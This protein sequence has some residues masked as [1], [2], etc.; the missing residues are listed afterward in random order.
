M[1][2]LAPLMV[3]LSLGASVPTAWS[4]P[5]TV[6]D[7]TVEVQLIRNATVR[8]DFSGTTFLVDPMLSAKGEF[9][10]FPGTYRSELRNPLVDLPF[11]AKEVLDSVEAVVVTHTHTD[12]WDE[13]AQKAIPKDLPVFT[14]NEADAKMIRSQGFKDVRVLDGS[15]TFKGVKLSKTGGQHG[16]DLWFADPVRSEAMGPVMGVV[17]SAP[18]TKTVYVAG[19]TVWRPEVDQALEQH[20]PDVVILNT[21]SALMSGFEQHPIIMGKQDTLQATKAAPNAAIVAVH[22]DSVNHMSLSRKELSEFVKGQKIEKSVLI[23][24]DGESMKF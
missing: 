17:F 22:M 4:A 23:P 19:D 11:S 24:A 20:K 3:S 18:Q 21:G 6:T 13:A 2:V 15:T 12:H 10:G 5:E 1:K 7:T 14:Q 16:T 9:P 8:I